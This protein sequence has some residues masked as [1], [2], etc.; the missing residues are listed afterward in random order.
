MNHWPGRFARQL[1]PRR[2]P[3]PWPHGSSD[4]LASA[5]ERVEDFLRVGA[6]IHAERLTFSRQHAQMLNKSPHGLVRSLQQPTMYANL[7]AIAIKTPGTH[8]TFAREAVM[9]RVVASCRFA[10]AR[11]IYA[12]SLPHQTF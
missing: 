5:E 4:P 11:V 10:F 2:F 3:V 9:S 12:A 1:K 7:F 6:P 8:G